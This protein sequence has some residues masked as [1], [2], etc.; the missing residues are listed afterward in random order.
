MLIGEIVNKKDQAEF[1]LTDF[2][3]LV[4]NLAEDVSKDFGLQFVKAI[5][6][7]LI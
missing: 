5:V 4:E 3:E 1:L 7:S 2:P 6:M